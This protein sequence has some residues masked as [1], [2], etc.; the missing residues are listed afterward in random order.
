M[1]PGGRIVPAE[2]CSGDI[3]IDLN[4]NQQLRFFSGCCLLI[5]YS[6]YAS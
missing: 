6:R 5:F 4:K 3:K 2:K 1:E